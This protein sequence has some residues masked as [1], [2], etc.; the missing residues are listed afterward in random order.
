[1]K[2]TNIIIL[3][4]SAIPFLSCK[5]VPDSRQSGTVVRDCT[6]THLRIAENRDYLVCNAEALADKKEGEDVAL[7]FVYTK[8]CTERDGKIMCMMYHENK[9]VIRVK[10]V[11]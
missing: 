7:T 10:S 4:V 2:A 9:G 3:A 1:M 11:K 6:G 5:S 8:E